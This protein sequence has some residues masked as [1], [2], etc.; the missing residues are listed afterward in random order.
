MEDAASAYMKAVGSHVL[1][2]NEETNE[3]LLKAQ[4]GDLAARDRII[5]HNM[6]WVIKLSKKYSGRGLDI[7]ELMSEGVFGLIHAIRKCDTS[8]AKF[9]TYCTYWIESYMDRASMDKGRS[10]RIPIHR[11]KEYRK[12]LKIQKSYEAAH[13]EYPSL[14]HIADRVS[15]EP[16]IVRKLIDEQQS[17]LSLDYQP[18]SHDISEASYDAFLDFLVSDDED[19]GLSIDN[20]RRCK[21]LKEFVD[22]LPERQKD[23][24]SLRFGLNGYDVHTFEKAGEAL[25]LSRE[26]IRQIQVVALNSLKGMLKVAEPTH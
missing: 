10:I 13:G 17:I 2:E 14:D 18:P 20:I 1:L 6:R 9:S 25:S 16:S 15:L 7:G 8:K 23:V 24:I 19:I 22:K 12:I 11:Y 3:L 21:N 4:S 26:R 5:L